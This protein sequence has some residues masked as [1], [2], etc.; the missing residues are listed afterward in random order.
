[1]DFCTDAPGYLALQGKMA[2]LSVPI[3]ARAMVAQTLAF[4]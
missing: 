4:G 2:G 1:M 3:L